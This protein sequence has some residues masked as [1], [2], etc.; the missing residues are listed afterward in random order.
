VTTVLAYLRQSRARPGESA[1]TSLSLE[2][3][4]AAIEAWANAN[5][6]TLLPPIV[7]HDETGRTLHRPGMI[8]LRA[9]AAER[10][11][12]IVAVYKYDRFA[13]NVIGQELAVQELEA[14]GVQVVSIT[15]PGGKLSRHILSAIAEYQS[16]QHG[17]RLADIKAAQAAR[18]IYPFPR[19]PYGWRR[20][21]SEILIHDAEA[22]IVREMFGRVLS[23]DT[24]YQIARD[25]ERRGV[26]TQRGAAWSIQALR[27]MAHNPAYGGFIR[28]RGRIVAEAVNLPPIIDR[29]TWEAVQTILGKR[30]KTR[31]ETNV[32]SWLNGL[33]LHQCG[34][35]MYLSGNVVD[36][37]MHAAF[38]CRRAHMAGGCP[39]PKP[40]VRA[41]KLEPLARQALAADLGRIVSLEDAVKR[42]ERTA[43][44][45]D[46]QRARADLAKRRAAVERR[47]ARARALWLDGSDD[48]AA[49][50]E[51]S[52]RF[53]AELAAID[54]D[55][56]ALPAA[57]DPTIY[58]AAARRLGDVA[59]VIAVAADDDV[60]A[61]LETVGTVVYGPEGVR[62]SYIS[63]FDAFV[64]EGARGAV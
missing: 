22:A 63:P 16:E 60:R 11:G 53:A 8:A 9:N 20:D 46:A 24:L 30:A 49:W 37:R 19:V 62:V 43:G 54:A 29:A 12:C 14:A 51:E 3:Q 47:R 15:E 57:P 2:Q 52:A 42:A 58:A 56:A 36:G 41:R 28:H 21:K 50:R 13:R 26:P 55:E 35:R 39:E 59:G 23:G 34:E 18:G 32:S 64:G 25:L 33:V 6:H 10:P 48:L 5:G 61:I 38:V 4:S 31:G 44:G 45:R 40:T 7:D 1:E 17:E 27:Q